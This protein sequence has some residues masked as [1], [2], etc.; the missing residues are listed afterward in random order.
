MGSPAATSDAPCT[1]CDAG[2]TGM[3]SVDDARA[4]LLKRARPLMDIEEVDTASALGRV[5]GCDVYATLDVPATDNSAM[6]GYAVSCGMSGIGPAVRLPVSQRVVAG[7]WAAPLESG[8]AARIFTGAPLPPGA[9][10]VVMQEQCVQEPEGYVRITGAVSP[11]QHVRRAGSDIAAGSRVLSGGTRLRPPEL[12]IAASIGVARVPV[13]RR[14]RVALFSTGNE[15]LMPGEPPRP[16]ALYNSNHFV[17]SGLL[18]ALGAEV[19]DGGVLHDTTE[20]TRV[21]LLVAADRADLILT[22]GGVSVGEEDHVRGAV[23]NLGEIS[24]WRVAVKPGK[25]LAFGRVAQTPFIGLPGNPVSALVTFCL[26]VRPYVLR[27][28]GATDV[29]P[30]QFPVLADF[31]WVRPG[32]R[33]E[34]LRARLTR[35]EGVLHAEVYC[36]QG[37]GV[38]TSVGWAHGLVK[39]AAGQVVR[40]GEPVPFTP[41]TELFH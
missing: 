32:P 10:A 14:L 8:T 3:L 34:Y 22:S 20:V 17:L 13:L 27:C 11:G 6:D 40:R 19:V 12:G 25:P 24:L 35:A 29:E 37:S 18:H 26:F 2:H 36:D 5:L 23:E 7:D 30:Q 31:D 41:F 16:G 39:I 9:D 21:A 28:Q 33:E 1:T 4:F 38:L 15:L